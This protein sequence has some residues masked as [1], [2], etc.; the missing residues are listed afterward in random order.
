MLLPRNTAQD[1]PELKGPAYSR[2]DPVDCPDSGFGAGAQMPHVRGRVY[3][4][5]DGAQCF[6]VG[7]DMDSRGTDRGMYWHNRL[8]VHPRGLSFARPASFFGGGKG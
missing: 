2:L 3:R 5:G 8:L 6:A 4:A 7:R 1:D